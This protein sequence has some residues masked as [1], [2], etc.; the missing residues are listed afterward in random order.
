MTPNIRNGISHALL[1]ILVLL[2]SCEQTETKKH[3]RVSPTP[4]GISTFLLDKLTVDIPYSESRPFFF[5]NKS[6][7]FFFGQTQKIDQKNYAL[8][9]G[10]HVGKQIVLRDYQLYADGRSLV[11]VKRQTELRPHELVRM[12]HAGKE[13]FHLFD[14][15]SVLA[16]DFTPKSTVVKNTLGI[17]VL[18]QRHGELI[19]DQQHNAI[20]YQTIT[21]NGF[22]A[23]GERKN[24]PAKF[25]GGRLEVPKGKVEFLIAYGKNKQEALTLLD[26]ARKNAKTWKNEREN[27]LLNF[28]RTNAMHSSSPTFNADM[29]WIHL[30]MD[31]MLINHGKQASLMTGIPYANRNLSEDCFSSFTGAILVTGEFEVAK[32]ILINFSNYQDRDPASKTYGAIPNEVIDGRPVYSAP[33][34]SL[35]FISALWHYLKYSGDM[36]L[37]DQLY[38][39]V[40]L[41]LDGL[42]HQ[43]KIDAKGYLLHQDNQTWM[44][45]LDIEG[46]FIFVP[47]GNRAVEVEAS[48][49]DALCFSAEM[50]ALTAHTDDQGKWHNLSEKMVYH[51]RKDFTGLP[52]QG[53]ADHVDING[54]RDFTFRCNQLMG[55]HLLKDGYKANEILEHIWSKLVYPFGVSTIAKSEK[56]FVADYPVKSIRQGRV[57][58]DFNG[59]TWPRV[60]G[61]AMKQMLEVGQLGRAFRLFENINRLAMDRTVIGGVGEMAETNTVGDRA[62]PTMHG[63][64]IQS[65]ANAEQLRIWSEYFLGVLPE[66]QEK[67]VIL[68]PRIPLKFDYIDTQFRLG[69]KLCLFSYRRN[70]NEQEYTYDLKGFKGKITFNDLRYPDQTINI[71]GDEQSLIIVTNNE[72]MRVALQK[73]DDD[74]VN[75]TSVSYSAENMKAKKL[76]EASQIFA[77]T[78]FVTEQ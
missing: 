3:P 40:K 65:N 77:E 48:W 1:F 17:S 50:A 74:P 64:L 30:N 6:G 71:N 41:I 57:L 20:V 76:A 47:R 21:E 22:V 37:L 14:Q 62:L 18:G 59:Q 4:K 35:Q 26:K 70:E 56:D 16:I 44:S 69:K 78:D 52:S 63:A 61:V 73:G 5:T 45:G 15:H 49:Y 66:L 72:E 25:V 32:Q 38:P 29:Q 43:G 60:T 23:V 68:A 53:L 36:S 12:H 31:A 24:Q 55:L 67:R 51:F 46:K 11:K 39:H 54:S 2:C 8:Y 9:A 58:A 27:R 10:W 19:F 33:A 13:V 42:E 34:A 75:I 28:L 7:D